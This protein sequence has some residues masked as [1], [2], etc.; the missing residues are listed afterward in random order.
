MH[1]GG[2]GVYTNKIEKEKYIKQL[3]NKYK[4]TIT[5]NCYKALTNKTI[6]ILYMNHCQEVYYKNFL[7]C[8]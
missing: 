7:F 6:A 2:W 5:E 8:H 4:D 3:A 1:P